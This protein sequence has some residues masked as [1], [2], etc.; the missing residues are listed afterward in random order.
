MSTHLPDWKGPLRLGPG[1]RESSGWRLWSPSSHLRGPSLPLLLGALRVFS[2]DFFARRESRYFLKKKKI[3]FV[4]SL[5]GY[6]KT[7]E[8]IK[9]TP[10]SQTGTFMCTMEKTDFQH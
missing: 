6:Q 3:S 2:L 9:K 4:S 5:F 8:T 10:N 7:G 1:R